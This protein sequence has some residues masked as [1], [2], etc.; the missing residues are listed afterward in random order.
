MINKTKVTILTGERQAG[1]TSML[2]KICEQGIYNKK[3]IVGV[4][5]PAVFEGGTKT[6][7]DTWLLPKKSEDDTFRFANKNKEEGPHWKFLPE[8][9]DAINMHLAKLAKKVEQNP[10]LQN[11]QML[12][13]DELGFLE[14]ERDEGLIEA[15]R[16]LDEGVFNEALI[17]IRPSLVK[18]AK[19]RWNVAQTIEP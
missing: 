4:I 6:A 8:A 19:A 13:I 14:F 5:T 2:K 3:E 10:K 18:T 1:K 17:V 12:I 16:I 15:M 11:S 7:I 9:I